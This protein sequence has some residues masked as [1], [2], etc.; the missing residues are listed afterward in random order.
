MRTKLRTAGISVAVGAAAAAVTLGVATP[1][2]AKSDTWLSGPRVAQARHAFRLTV[3]V[4]D[5]G[6][7]QKAFA[8]LQVRGAHGQFQWY[9][10]WE[11]L[12][13]TNQWS[14]DCTFTVTDSHRGTETF[15][16]ILTG[17]YA[18]TNFVTVV[19]RLAS[20]GSCRRS[21]DGSGLPEAS[22]RYCSDAISTFWTRT[23]TRTD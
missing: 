10:G 17:Y 20:L 9:G 15:R 13:L 22:P 12:H 1:A 14:E 16:A 19:V 18:P 11:K 7:A 8:R 2:F 3:S 21:R 23:W 4:G 5:D 6:G